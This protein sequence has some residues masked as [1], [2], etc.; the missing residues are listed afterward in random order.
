MKRLA[1]F[2]YESALVMLVYVSIRIPGLTVFVWNMSVP[3]STLVSRSC[4]A[5]EVIKTSWAMRPA[6]ELSAVL[7]SS[8]LQQEFLTS[9]AECVSVCVWQ[10]LPR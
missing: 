10:F 9:L 3:A 1:C 4:D 8:S 6:R 7:D 2:K 5:V